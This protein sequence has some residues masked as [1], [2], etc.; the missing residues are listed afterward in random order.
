MTGRSCTIDIYG[1]AGISGNKSIVILQG[2]AKYEEPD[3]ISEIK[4]EKVVIR[5]RGLYNIAG[6]RLS[7]PV[8]DQ[9]YINDGKKF[10][11]KK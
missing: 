7:Q 11:M 1:T 2:D 4:S 5:K 8:K 3:A 9:L 6:Q 10:L